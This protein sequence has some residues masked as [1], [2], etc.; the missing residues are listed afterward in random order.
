MAG[1][2]PPYPSPYRTYTLIEACQIMEELH[3]YPTTRNINWVEVETGKP[4]VIASTGG[5][6]PI[7]QIK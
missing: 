6:K 2:E 3:R 7:N 1:N 5:T 4:V